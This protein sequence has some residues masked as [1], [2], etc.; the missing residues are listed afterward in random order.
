MIASTPACGAV[1]LEDR[2]LGVVALA[3]LARAEGA[4][5]LE[6]APV[7]AARRRFI[8][9]SGD[10][11]REARRLAPHRRDRLERIEVK[12]EPGEGIASGVSTSR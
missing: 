8:W 10:V 11:L 4:R 1:E 12:I 5:D 6:D 9:Y 2:E 7:P 3:E